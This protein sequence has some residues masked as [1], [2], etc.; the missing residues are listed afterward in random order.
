M[1]T[2]N[3]QHYDAQLLIDGEWTDA[4][5]HRSLD[6]VNPATGEVINNCAS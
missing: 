5:E 4:E 3:T 1:D 2:T 6:I